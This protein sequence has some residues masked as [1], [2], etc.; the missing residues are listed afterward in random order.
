MTPAI[1]C[2]MA[3]PDYIE[4]IRCA[5][6]PII[7]YMGDVPI[8]SCPYANPDHIYLLPNQHVEGEAWIRTPR[9]HFYG[10]AISDL[11]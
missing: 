1:D 5:E 6:H 9:L 7:G 11:L 2:V 8:V 10:K 4:A 3:V